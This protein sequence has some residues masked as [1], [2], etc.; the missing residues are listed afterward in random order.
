MALGENFDSMSM[1]PYTAILAADRTQF[2]HSAGYFSIPSN[3]SIHEYVDEIPSLTSCYEPR[4]SIETFAVSVLM[5]WLE[6]TEDTR[7][8]N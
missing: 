5:S 6:G 4:P 8:K 2:C 7:D 1:R 3:I